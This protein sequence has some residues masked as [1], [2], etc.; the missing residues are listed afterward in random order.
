MTHCLYQ[1][2]RNEI[3]RVMPIAADTESRLV[4]TVTVLRYKMPCPGSRVVF[5][6]VPNFHCSRTC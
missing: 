6:L 1:G 4:Q 2:A 3:L 5:Y